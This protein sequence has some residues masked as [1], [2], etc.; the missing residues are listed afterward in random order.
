MPRNRVASEVTVNKQR[1]SRWIKTRKVFFMWDGHF[2]PSAHRAAFFFFF[3]FN[4]CFGDVPLIDRCLGPTSCYELPSDSGSTGS[5]MLC[6]A[7]CIHRMKQLLRGA[8]HH[9]PWYGNGCNGF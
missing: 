4:F 6:V 1:C 2:G 9:V 8:S 7:R 5:N 3:F